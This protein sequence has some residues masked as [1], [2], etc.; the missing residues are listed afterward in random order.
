ML[1][2]R[3]GL[4]I[5]ADRLLRFGRCRKRHSCNHQDWYD[6]GH[7][8]QLLSQLRSSRGIL[9]EREIKADQP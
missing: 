8:D 5:A 1:G 7:A 9:H 2:C 3:D 4:P 6:F